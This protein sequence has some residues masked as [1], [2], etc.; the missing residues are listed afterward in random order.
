[1]TIHPSIVSNLG[2]FVP[3]NLEG[4][5]D[6][7]EIVNWNIKFFSGTPE[8]TEV[9]AKIM[10]EIRADIFVLQEIDYGAMDN[11]IKILQHLQVGT[12]KVVYGN[13]GGDIRVAFV[14]NLET[15]RAKDDIVE[16][17]NKDNILADNGKPAFPRLPLYGYFQVRKSSQPLD[18]EL[19]GVH[20]KSQRGSNKSWLQ[21]K[22]A[23]ESLSTW[24]LNNSKDED[25]I[26]VG[27]FNSP[28]DREEW[29]A[30][31]RLEDQDRIKF[32]MS[33]DINERSHFYRGKDSR[34][35]M[36]LTTQVTPAIKL[37]NGREAKV[38]TWEQ[39]IGDNDSQEFINIIKDQISDHLPVL[40]RYYWKDTDEE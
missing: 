21:R 36:V 12:Y 3:D 1:M 4:S 28:P 33:N 15:V 17:F 14:Y 18:F 8:R 37:S 10:G 29:T 32:E 11:V 35:D 27:D 6:Y 31:E 13:T 2:D 25:V 39:L 26:I 40:S 20:L 30:F 5:D 16:L 34:L 9:I 24:L 19:I 22:K 7:L 23:A 38:I